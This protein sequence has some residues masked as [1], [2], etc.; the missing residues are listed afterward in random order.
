MQIALLFVRREEHADHR[1][2]VA[3]DVIVQSGQGVVILA[4]EAF[5]RV[6]V[7]LGA[8]RVAVGTKYLARLDGRPAC[9]PADIGED[10]AQ[11]VGEQV[12]G[13]VGIQVP[14]QTIAQEIVIGVP[15]V[16]AGAT[17]VML[18]TTKGI[19]HQ[20]SAVAGDGAGQ[21]AGATIVEALLKDL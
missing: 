7:A 18:F 15:L 13:A 3:R 11:R 20:G 1:I 5:R 6:E 2:V 19:D 17:V 4:G 21:D 12:E 9:R 8:T 16:G 14:N 10:A